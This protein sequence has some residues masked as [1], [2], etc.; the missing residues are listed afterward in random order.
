MLSIGTVMNGG[1]GAT[2]ARRKG[3]RNGRF[4]RIE[5][6]NLTF[7]KDAYIFIGFASCGG[8]L[9]GGSDILGL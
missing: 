7:R 2:S 6:F 3:P 8:R 5:G 4:S 9:C 1:E